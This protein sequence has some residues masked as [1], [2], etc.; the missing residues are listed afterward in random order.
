MTTNHTNLAEAISTDVVGL[1]KRRN[2]LANQL[3]DAEC[4][5]WTE[6]VYLA[7]QLKEGRSI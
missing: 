6:M 4:S 5:L 3:E 2:E 1:E 7:I